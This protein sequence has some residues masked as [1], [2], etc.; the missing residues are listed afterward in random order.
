[1]LENYL[2]GNIRD[3]RKQAKRF[4][5]LR[6]VRA[7]IDDYGFSESRA[8]LTAHYLK[9]GEGWQAACDAR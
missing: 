8:I 4:G 7:L 2:N 5:G 1:M 3:A 6:I 9:T